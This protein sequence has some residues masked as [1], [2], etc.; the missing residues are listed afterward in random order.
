M[1]PE[2]IAG[3]KLQMCCKLHVS[4][5]K[6]NKPKENTKQNQ[7]KAE[8]THTI[9]PIL[10]HIKQLIFINDNTALPLL[11]DKCLYTSAEL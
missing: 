8:N 11:R 5:T 1:M 3:I 10:M 4:K 7:T 9:S 6:Q 2:R